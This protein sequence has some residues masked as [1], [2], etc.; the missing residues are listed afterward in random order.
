MEAEAGSSSGETWTHR[1]KRLAGELCGVLEDAPNRNTNINGSYDGWRPA[2]GRYLARNRRRSAVP[3]IRSLRRRPF[4]LPK[5]GADSR[6]VATGGACSD[7]ARY[8]VETPS[9]SA[10]KMRV[11]AKPQA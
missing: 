7:C 2:T 8:G 10:H 5:I 4:D 1:R 6:V 11:V 3:L 9:E